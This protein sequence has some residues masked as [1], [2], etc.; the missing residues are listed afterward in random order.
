MM[1]C[2]Y[3]SPLQC[4]IAHKAGTTAEDLAAAPIGTGSLRKIACRPGQA[5]RAAR[6][7]AHGERRA[8]THTAWSINRARWLSPCSSTVACGYGSPLSRLC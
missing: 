4:A 7:A 5:S 8:R 3:G 1:A 2:G 6:R